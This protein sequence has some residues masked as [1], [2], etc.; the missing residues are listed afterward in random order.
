MLESIV[1]LGNHFGYLRDIEG[2]FDCKS[3]QVY[4]SSGKVPGV[5]DEGFV[6]ASQGRM[7][8]YERHH[9]HGWGKDK[10]E[11]CHCSLQLQV[12]PGLREDQ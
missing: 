5:E 3:E 1:L 12:S 4:G 8:G 9:S 2:I 7:G 10:Q 6:R 11:E